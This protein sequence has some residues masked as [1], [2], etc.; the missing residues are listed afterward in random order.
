MRHDVGM[1]T[2]RRRLVLS[3][4]A[5]A[6][7]APFA[8]GA[9]RATGIRLEVWKDPACGCCGEWITHA[10]EAGFAI[11][12]HDTGNAAQRAKAGIAPKY[13]SCHT[14]LVDGYAIEGHVPA[15][16]LLRLLKER[17][18]AIGLAVPGMVVGSPG[19]EQGGRI[20][21]YEVLLLK[22]DGSASTYARYP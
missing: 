2:S 21:P 6:L 8:I 5:S 15:R 1:N 11:T 9:P 3:A 18:K 17:P 19:M 16:E 7:A 20:D 12:V 4:I 22:K 14:A 10:R 13:G